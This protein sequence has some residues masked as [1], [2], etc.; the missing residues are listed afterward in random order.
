MNLIKSFI[1][2]IIYILINLDIV[3]PFGLS[4]FVY[5]HKLFNFRTDKVLTYSCSN[6]IN[7]KYIFMMSKSLSNFGKSSGKEELRE[8]ITE[9]DSFSKIVYTVPTLLKVSGIAAIPMS[10]ILCTVIS[11]FHCIPANAFGSVITAFFTY[12]GKSRLDFARETAVTPAIAQLVLD[13]DIDECQVLS[14]R[15]ENLQR[16]F[17]V[18]N[19]D[20]IDMC[21]CVYERYLIG[22]AKTRLIQLSE[23][24]QLRQLRQA[25]SLSNL[26]VGE[27]HV[28]VADEFY[29]NTCR[30]VSTKELKDPGHPVRMVLDKILFLSERVFRQ[31]GETEE[32]FKYEMSRVSKALSLNFD[33]AMSRVVNIINLFYR[34]VLTITREKL[35]IIT[36]S[37]HVLNE[38]K[39]TLGINDIAANDM[40]LAAFS[41]EVR[42]F[43]QSNDGIDEN[44]FSTISFSENAKLKLK[45]LVSILEL[46]VNEAEY[47]IYTQTSAH[48][49][50]TVMSCID[51]VISGVISP[52]KAWRTL[53]TRRYELLLNVYFMK[54]LLTSVVL[55]T[56]G[57]LLEDSL[58]LWKVNDKES[59]YGKLLE[60]LKAKDA[61]I[62]ILENSEWDEFHIKNFVKTF[63]G[64]LSRSSANAFIS[65]PDRLKL[66]GVFLTRSVQLSKMECYNTDDYSLKIKHLKEILGISDLEEEDMLRSNFGPEFYKS[67]SMV[68]NEIMDDDHTPKL[69]SNLKKLFR[70][71]I[72]DYTLPESLQTEFTSSLYM[73]AASKILNNATSAV[74]TENKMLQLDALCDI[75]KLNTHTKYQIHFDVFGA[76]YR[77]RVLESMGHN[78]VIQPKLLSLLTDL[79]NRLRISNVGCRKLFLEALEEKLKV[80]VKLIVGE[81]EH[82]VLSP[83]QLAQKTDK[84]FSVNFS[85]TGNNSSVSLNLITKYVSGRK[86]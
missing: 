18:H 43:L 52:E 67:L 24:R 5:S 85:T 13:H 63:F 46:D 75:F 37:S 80:M 71:I 74:P 42:C 66:Y 11:P 49:H 40:H 25:L 9:V 77:S 62:S 68:M 2:T 60:T 72:T 44:N 76:V 58:N 36:I 8:L 4:H 48:Y 83:H 12:I 41:D 55:Q 45:K 86:M 29:K 81:L 54:D 7:R 1:F 50:D 3:S 32:A 51:K 34:R 69:V 20:F 78:G 30:L 27:A 26:C 35:D 65:H 23:L 73:Q 53:S 16:Y 79:Q 64:S 17:R 38:T 33:V 70:K 56:M 47:E 31:G 82:T 21:Q 61:C 59:T 14:E 19:E 6:D 39:V 28:K 22:V 10:M 15:I 57:K 84:K